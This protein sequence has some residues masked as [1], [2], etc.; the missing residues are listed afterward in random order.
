MG[1]VVGVAVTVIITIVIVVIIA[2]RGSIRGIYFMIIDME[3]KVCIIDILQVIFTDGNNG[4]K[5]YLYCTIG[6]SLQSWC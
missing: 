6:I 2:C 5:P 1:V 4:N 3:F